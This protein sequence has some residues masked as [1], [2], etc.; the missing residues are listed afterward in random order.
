MGLEY[1]SLNAVIPCV[2][3]GFR[4]G[5]RPRRWPER[6]FTG[7]GWE[8]FMRSKGGG[9]IRVLEYSN[10]SDGCGFIVFIARSFYPRFQR[11]NLLRERREK[12]MDF[13]YIVA[14][15]R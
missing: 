12:G 15:T 13:N 10:A 7:G 6:F 1:E 14:I 11:A 3:V 9:P 8:N 5:S 4:H 2:D